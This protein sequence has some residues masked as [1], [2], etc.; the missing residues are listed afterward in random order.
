MRRPHRLEDG[1]PEHRRVPHEVIL[2][3]SLEETVRQDEPKA[4]LWCGCR[5]LEDTDTHGTPGSDHFGCP[6]ATAPVKY[7]D[8][9]A[10]T[11]A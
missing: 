7:Q 8:S 6:F 4:R 10:S 9:I 11:Q 1:D 2:L 3:G 5:R